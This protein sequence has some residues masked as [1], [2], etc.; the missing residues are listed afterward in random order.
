MI[1]YLDS[2][3]NT[4]YTGV[5]SSP[6][7]VPQLYCNRWSTFPVMIILQS[8][9]YS[10]D[11][12]FQTDWHTNSHCGDYSKTLTD[13]LYWHK[14]GRKNTP[15]MWISKKDLLIKQSKAEV[16]ATKCLQ[17]QSLNVLKRNIIH[18]NVYTI[19]KLS[20]VNNVIKS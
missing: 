1:S 5:N 18:S 7:C 17:H 15:Q 11:K 3:F 2:P 12:K 4:M 19:N 13:V 6:L 8:K 16:I 9:S 20:D 10:L 14:Y